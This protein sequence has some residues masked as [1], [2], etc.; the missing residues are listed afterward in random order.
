MRKIIQ[1]DIPKSTALSFSRR[2]NTILDFKKLTIIVGF[3]LI[4]YASFSQYRVY[5]KLNSVWSNADQ[6][7]AT[8]GRI[9]HNWRLYHRINDDTDW[10]LYY[11]DENK[12]RDRPSQNTNLNHRTS[13]YTTETTFDHSLIGFEGGSCNGQREELSVRY[14]MSYY[15]PGTWHTLNLVTPGGKY[16]AQVEFYYTIPATNA[17]V[18]YVDG[19][20]TFNICYDDYF[21][22]YAEHNIPR[23]SGITYQWEYHIEGKRKI[24][25]VDNPESCIDNYG[26]DY[27]VCQQIRC[28]DEGDIP[29]GAEDN[30][31]IETLENAQEQGTQ[32]APLAPPIPIGDCCCF[33]PATLPEEVDDWR[34]LGTTSYNSYS[35]LPSQISGL[36]SE[37]SADDG[38]VRVR[39]RVRAVMPNQTTSYRTSGYKT[40]FPEAPSVTDV[41]PVAPICRGDEGSIEITHGSNAIVGARYVYTITQYVAETEGV[42][43]LQGYSD[44]SLSCSEIQNYPYVR[45]YYCGTGQPSSFCRGFI[46]NFTATLPSNRKILLDAS[47]SVNRDSGPNELKLLPGVYSIKIEYDGSS[48]AAGCFETH[49]FAIPESPYEDLTLSGNSQP[50]DGTPTCEGAQ[51]GKARINLSKGLADFEWTLS[52]TGL[53]DVTG[54]ASSRNFNTPAEVKAG[55]DYTLSINDHCENY[56]DLGTVR[57]NSDGPNLNARGT[58]SIVT[59]DDGTPN[60]SI[61]A[62]ARNISGKSYTF[63]LY[64]DGG[65]KVGNTINNGTSNTH[66]FSNLN[67]LTYYVVADAT[68]CDSDQSSNIQVL[69]PTDLNISA[70]PN[71]P[72][73]SDENGSISISGISR[74]RG[75]F[76]FSYT[77]SKQ[78][79]GMTDITGSRTNSNNFTFS[80]L[81]EGTYDLDIVDVCKGNQ[82]IERHS[83][84]IEA[85][86]PVTLED[87]SDEVL[88]CFDDEISIHI[89]WNQ[90]TDKTYN[91]GNFNVAITKNGSSVYTLNNHS[92][93]FINTPNL[94]VDND[95]SYDVQVTDGCSIIATTSFSITSDATSAVLA[96]VDE[97]SYPNGFGLSCP[98]ND[99][100]R[101]EIRVNGGVAK[102]SGDKNYT[103][104]LLDFSGSLVSDSPS[105]CTTNDGRSCFQF[106]NLD[107]STE[108]RVEVTDNNSCTKTFDYGYISSPNSLEI[109]SPTISDFTTLYGFDDNGDNVDE[110]Y[111]QCKND[112]DVAL[113][114]SIIGGNPPYD[115][116]LF[117]KES[118]SDSW[119]DVAEQTDT[120]IN[121]GEASFSALKAGWYK[122]EVTD[123]FNCDHNEVS[124]EIK[125]ATQELL[126]TDISAENTYGHGGNTT[127]YRQNDGAIVVLAEGGVGDKTYTLNGGSSTTKSDNDHTFSNLYAIN[128]AGS[129][130]DYTVGLT[131]E[132]GCTWTAENIS[133]GFQLAT[134]LEVTFGHQIISPQD[135]SEGL[136]ILCKGDAATVRIIS[137]GGLYN[138]RLIVTGDSSINEIITDPDGNL[139]DTIYVDLLAG[140]YQISVEDDLSCPDP[141][142]TISVT[143]DEPASYVSV[144][145][146]NII[147]PVCIGGDNGEIHVSAADGTPGTTGSEYAFQLRKEGETE[148]E[149]KLGTSAVFYRPAGD[150]GLSAQ[151]YIVKVIDAYG[152]EDEITVTMVRNPDPLTLEVDN[153]SPPS[154]YGGTDGSISVTATNFD[155]IDGNSLLFRI[156]G[157]HFGSSIK[158]SLHNVNTNTN[159]VTFQNLE[160]T[161][162][163]DPYKVWVEDLNSCVDTAFQFQENLDLIAPQ[164]LDLQVFEQIRPSCFNGADGSLNL[165]AAGGVPPYFISIE[166]ESFIE[167][168]SPSYRHHFPNLTAGEYNFRLRDSNYQPSQPT[169]ELEFDFVVLPGRLI[170][171]SATST[172][173]TCFEGSDG[174]IDLEVNVIN[175]AE[176]YDPGLL[177][178]YWINNNVSSDTI[179]TDEDLVGIPAGNYTVKARYDVD[180][181][182][183]VNEERIVVKDPDSPFEISD[184]K[185]YNTQ[186]G[187]TN[188]GRIILSVSG[189]YASTTSEFRLNGG[190]WTGFSSLSIVINNLSIG[191]YVLEVRQVGTDCS[192]SQ[193]F[194]ISGGMLVLDVDQVISPS[195]HGGSNGEIHL[196]SNESGIEFAQVGEAFIDNNGVF[197]G[198]IAGEYRFV[199]RRI[200]DTGCESDTINVMLSEPDQLIVSPEVI[201]DADC[202]QANGSA[203][204][205]ATG[206]TGD[207]IFSWKDDSGVNVDHNN[208]LPGNYIVTVTDENGCSDTAPIDI[209]NN[210]NLTLGYSIVDI[211]DCDYPN[212]SASLSITNGS[213][214]YIVNGVDGFSENE[215]L[216]E[217]LISGDTIISV[218]DYRGCSQEILISVPSQNTLAV[219]LEAIIQTT[220]GDTN[221]SVEVSVSGGTEP[222]DFNW[223]GYDI[224]SP[225]LTDLGVGSYNLSITDAHGCT[226]TETYDVTPANGISSVDYTIVDPYCE[227]S[228]GSI[229]IT[230]VAGDF[231]PYQIN[232]VFESNTTSIGTFEPSESDFIIPDLGAGNYALQV[233]DDNGC[234]FPVG[235]I[236]LTDDPSF[237][238]SVSA[239]QVDSS[240][241]GLGVGQ[242]MVAVSGGQSPYTFSW[243]D[244]ND[245]AL[246]IT[247]ESADG[248]VAGEYTVTVE[249]D[250]GCSNSDAVTIV[251]RAD[252]E[253]ELLDVT[254]SPSGASNGS[255]TVLASNGGG[256]PFSYS[257]V[258][259]SVDQTNTTGNFTGLTPG[260][261][262]ASAIDA[263][264]CQTNSISFNIASTAGLEVRILSLTD[265]T[266]SSATDASAEASASGGISPY[267]FSWDGVLGTENINDLSVGD[268]YVVVEDAIGSVDSLYFSVDYL[269]PISVQTFTSKTSCPGTCD[270]EV[271]LVVANGS[272][273]YLISWDH[274]ASGE[275]LSSLCPGTYTYTISD[276]NNENCV[277]SGEV[278]ID[279]FDELA[280]VLSNVSA[281]TCFDGTDGFVKVSV[282]GG[283]GDYAYLWD[284]G[285]TDNQLNDVTP[286]NYAL[287]VSDNVLGCSVTSSFEIPQTPAIT[288]SDVAVSAPSCFGG[289]DGAI[290]IALANASSPRITWD[291]GQIGTK[292]TG[293]SAGAYHFDVMDAKGCSY[294]D[295]VVLEDRPELIVSVDSDNPLCYGNCTGFIDLDISGGTTPY[296]IAWSH[297]PRTQSLDNLC[298]GSYHYTVSDK[299]G[300]EVTGTVEITS[301]DDLV[302]ALEDFGIPSCNGDSDGSI[303]VE[304]TGGVGGYQYQW[305][306]GAESPVN[307]NIEAGNYSVVVTDQNEC[308]ASFNYRLDEPL[309]LL[310]TSDTKTDPSCP[311]SEDGTISIFPSGGTPPYTFD[312]SDGATSQNRT[313]LR[314]GEYAVTIFD[315]SDCE[316]EKTFRLKSPNGLEIVNIKEV[317]PQCFGDENGSI[318]LDVSGGTAPYTFQWDNGS[319]SQN[320]T[321]IGE[322]TYS[323]TVTDDKDCEINHQ[324]SLQNPEKPKI[325]GLP[326]SSLLCEGGTAILE[327]DEDWIGYDWKGPDGFTAISK[328][329]MVTEEGDYTLIA[330]DANNCPSESFTTFVEVGNNILDADI[331]I[332]SEAFVFEP[333][334]FVDISLPVPETI[335]WVIPDDPNI[336]INNESQANIELL[337]LEVGTYE[338]GLKASMGNCESETFKSITV[339]E[340]TEGARAANARR[341]PEINVDVFPNPAISDVSFKVS[342]DSRDE[343]DLVLLSNI[344]NRTLLHEKL[345]G[346]YD[347]LVKWDVSELKAGVY[348][349]YIQQGDLVSSKRIVIH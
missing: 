174:E 64:T 168:T 281:P 127:C 124:F 102:S 288:L 141:E 322:D 219:T 104:R 3:L 158:D 49:Y 36:L 238:P 327:P 44:N 289:D 97:L 70:T 93:K 156:S 244:E 164:P 88:D 277:L 16:R 201:I 132:I 65:T 274:G 126:V 348:L 26:G 306:N 283:S 284:N 302:I 39:F 66:T 6:S 314:E 250:L 54:T 193:E 237:I 267:E 313:G 34:A 196:S 342:A 142:N 32:A 147:P 304:V 217:N 203:S 213:S 300:C 28:P 136:E 103:V 157:G 248:L 31:T 208:L 11:S 177:S 2:T 297:G 92:G 5:L 99:D 319:N 21:A 191:D 57:I 106:N 47:R 101:L 290:V 224:N 78:G 94:G 190:S 329:I 258:G 296:F 335:E 270:G 13:F 305:S 86:E 311:E 218:T 149:E 254:S 38:S 268:H 143:I 325:T 287:T 195:C 251:D 33:K 198:L 173:V 299:F 139:V 55:V 71:D 205:S 315:E 10:V 135:Q 185:V 328:R 182:V 130:I 8:D 341:E 331:L 77:L 255:A 133:N 233:I 62:V 107:E 189:G 252:P 122:F 80:D 7:C 265:A 17:P 121:D 161:N 154:C 227:Q 226:I 100:G 76:N 14:N 83:L 72:A 323:L 166:G 332:L 312:W 295:S 211:A 245:V 112:N 67:D 225:I 128:G 316:Y 234:L 180:S 247:T 326:E 46:G 159:T 52:A 345:K 165:Q 74:T 230:E 273:N 116:E 207:Y 241:C 118:S 53:P 22:L 96:D 18:T 330:I 259:E 134:P 210:P 187:T 266:C 35:R 228:T 105:N 178:L 82:A 346:S 183:C 202:G 12:T 343:V 321:D 204:V 152:C 275:S 188:S 151:N 40:F 249:D 303:S 20:Q 113:D 222:Y 79:G 184:I 271:D 87:I 169:C 115:V 1:K 340:P 90:D 51:D 229:T 240:A 339:K 236:V 192:H 179:S 308:T 172:P 260:L 317:D 131:D 123:D 120:D 43:D 89:E 170:D 162:I 48:S 45:D 98:E 334:V 324:F 167:I 349:L 194:S 276:V 91:S 137:R 239:S 206:G 56:A 199:A 256:S 215:I 221:G 214:P 242:A 220:C 286:G 25:Q 19:D 61:A 272:G 344:D 58:P 150:N 175:R 197:T 318:S 95:H 309:T 285:D 333:L 200:A 84:V 176:P 163:N 269:S 280:V 298:E 37:M 73:C 153:Q 337:F 27:E 186:C 42:C 60:G 155:L 144:A 291:N 310:T 292:A 114:L 63:E 81:T 41:D 24:I 257:L 223:E 262:E 138:H 307:S 293:L 261:Y 264:G 148:F 119:P 246:G 145:N 117:Y 69:G 125:E 140:N 59:C 110:W 15:N 181:T 108:Y 338:I 29:L 263:L 68:G 9:E 85:P 320:L 209:D 50:A 231:P 282:S 171:L 232:V 294:S 75:D 279:Q 336:V 4:S 23:S 301:P 146:D 347:Y 111:V 109:V 160:M 278:K 212:G 243:F 216:L 129:T 253:I 235:G 30:P